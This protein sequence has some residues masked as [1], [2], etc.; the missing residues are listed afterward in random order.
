LSELAR[1]TFTAAIQHTEPFPSLSNAWVSSFSSHLHC[2]SKLS[3]AV[4]NTSDRNGTS[5]F[6]YTQLKPLK[7]VCY[8]EGEGV[9]LLSIKQEEENEKWEKMTQK[10]KFADWADRHQYT[11]ILG[12]WASSLALAGGIIS[13]DK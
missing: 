9:R 13:R 6:Y 12:G 7:R 11:L 10:E 2:L 3:V 5:F 4:L 1:T 8:R